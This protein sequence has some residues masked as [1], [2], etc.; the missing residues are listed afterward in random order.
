MGYTK[1]QILHQIL[2]QCLKSPEHV[3]QNYEEKQVPSIV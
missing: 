3:E 1:S 2:M